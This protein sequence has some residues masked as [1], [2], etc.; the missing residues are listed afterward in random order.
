MGRSGLSK[1]LCRGRNPSL[2]IWRTHW[3]CQAGSLVHDLAG[4]ELH[5]TACVCRPDL[6]RGGGFRDPKI[7]FDVGVALLARLIRFIILKKAVLRPDEVVIRLAQQIR[8]GN[9]KR[10]S[11]PSNESQHQT[12]KIIPCLRV[13]GAMMLQMKKTSQEE[14]QHKE[15][16]DFN[17]Q[18]AW[19]RVWGLVRMD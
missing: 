4:G 7:A 14:K 19:C 15:K 17:S 18:S 12:S 9:E 13:W 11:I 16:G 2:R 5:K 1:G 6:V 10:G 3:L 8:V